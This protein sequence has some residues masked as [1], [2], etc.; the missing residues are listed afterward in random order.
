[1][2]PVRNP[3][4]NRGRNV[5]RDAQ[6]NPLVKNIDLPDDMK[7]AAPFQWQWA[8]PATLK[9]GHSSG[10]NILTPNLRLN[11][12]PLEAKRV[13]PFRIQAAET[14]PFA[15]SVA[16]LRRSHGHVRGQQ[17]VFQLH[18]EVSVGSRCPQTHKITSK[19]RLPCQ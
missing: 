14:L 17:G 13:G 1:M 4:Q 15:V 19:W 8:F 12:F 9:S 16:G 3:K 11:G 5:L 18:V 2:R 10:P 7:L 6:K